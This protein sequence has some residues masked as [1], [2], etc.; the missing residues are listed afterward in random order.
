MQPRRGR[1]TSRSP[2]HDKPTP[3]SRNLG[4]IDSDE[5][6]SETQPLEA[7]PGPFQISTYVSPVDEPTVQLP[8]YAVVKS[9]Y[10]NWL[11]LEQLKTMNLKLMA[12]EEKIDRIHRLVDMTY[13][14]T[15]T[16]PSTGP[17]SGI[18]TVTNWD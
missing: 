12:I 3:T 9:T 1:D 15:P 6:A 7:V 18:F 11:I 14:S 4:T 10:L 17:E 2:Q 13:K 5:D 16:T 8:K